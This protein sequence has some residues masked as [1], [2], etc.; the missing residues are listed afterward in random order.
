MPSVPSLSVAVQPH[1]ISFQ[2]FALCEI[3][4]RLQSP[5]A[6]LGCSVVCT[7]FAFAQKKDT[8]PVGGRGISAF[9]ARF[10]FCRVFIYNLCYFSLQR[11]REDG[12]GRSGTHGGLDFWWNTVYLYSMCITT[13][14]SCTPT[15]HSWVD[16]LVNSG[17]YGRNHNDAK[18]SY[19]LRDCRQTCRIRAPFYDIGLRM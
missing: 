11:P 13:L 19:L 2:N 8:R 17:C 9:S 3:A 1:C 14:Y 15:C 10:F 18:P 5:A 16:A 7:T 6:R 12:L 4:D